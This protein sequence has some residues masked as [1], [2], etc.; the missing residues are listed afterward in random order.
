MEG[1]SRMPQEA[2]FEHR[3]WLQILGDHS[4]FIYNALSP[5]EINDTQIAAQFINH[6]DQLL[7][8]ARMNDAAARLPELNKQAYEA[9]VNLRA[10]K[11]NLLDRLLL[12]QVS[13]GLTPTF[14]NHMVNELEEYKK[15][16]TALLEG[17]PVPRFTSLHYDLVW[18]PDAA[19]HAALFAMDLDAVEKR[20]IEKS[21]KFERHFNAFFLKAIELNGYLRTMRSQY[22]ALSRFHTDVNMEMSIFMAFLKEIEALEISEEL[23]SR[24]N[25]LIP[26][27]MYREECYY[28]LK[29]SA[30]G[31]VAAP[32]CDPAKPRVE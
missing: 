17:K 24:L 12:G 9:T 30:N 7:N 11:L 31:A 26:D 29:L 22:P 15:I 8:A 25:P 5:K 21:Q 1:E 3:F 4:R 13:I 19:G 23:L 16:L 18:L 10:F 27:H 28:I 6:F 20:L 2:L 14:I 32:A